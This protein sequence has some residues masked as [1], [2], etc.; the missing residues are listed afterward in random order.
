M[1]KFEFLRSSREE[2]SKRSKESRFLRI[3]N[4]KD[5]I[6]VEI[7]KVSQV[8]HEG[9]HRDRY[10]ESIENA[11]DYSKAREEVCSS[12]GV[13]ED[14]LHRFVM[15]EVKGKHRIL[16]AFVTLVDK[17]LT[18]PKT[19]LY[20]AFY[21]EGRTS[22]VELMN[23]VFDN[24]NEYGIN[25]ANIDNFIK[26]DPKK[27]D[28][29]WMYFKGFLLTDDKEMSDFSKSEVKEANDYRAKRSIKIED[30]EGDISTDDMHWFLTGSNMKYAIER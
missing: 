27:K 10:L 14:D 6:D 29:R 5:I 23:R 24:M 4:G 12:F 26:E 16:R 13:P 7:P 20:E 28:P 17:K 30:E 25:D 11:P 22:H 15:P 8:M 2:D 3:V 18:H 21:G 1:K 9:L 19:G